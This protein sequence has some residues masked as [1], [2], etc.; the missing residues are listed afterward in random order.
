MSG[1]ELA[2]AAEYDIGVKVLIFN[3]NVQG[4]VYRWQNKPAPLPSR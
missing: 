4:M 1:L 3:N 2:T